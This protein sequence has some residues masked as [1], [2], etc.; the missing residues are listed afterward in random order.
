M[1]HT[2]ANLIGCLVSTGLQL[3]KLKFDVHSGGKKV[4]KSDEFCFNASS[5]KWK[6]TWGGC[7][8][9]RGKE[10]KGKKVRVKFSEVPTA[11][12][13]HVIA[14]APAVQGDKRAELWNFQVEHLKATHCEEPKTKKEHVVPRTCS[15]SCFAMDLNVLAIR[16][17][18]N[19]LAATHASE[20]TCDG[21]EVNAFSL[22]SQSILAAQLRDR[23]S[24][25][26]GNRW[27]GVGEKEL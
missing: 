14:A 24:A 12:S 19:S 17:T 18:R 4:G 21:S 11:A 6:V 16:E 2:W 5:I 10:S 13:H 3:E 25:L 9:F 1:R 7:V 23:E 27:G 15:K 8:R 26:W 22:A 20:K